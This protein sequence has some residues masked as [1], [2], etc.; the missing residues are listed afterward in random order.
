VCHYP[1]NP[2]EYLDGRRS[3]GKTSDFIL[4]IGNELDHKDAVRTIELLSS[5]FPFRHLVSLGPKLTETPYLRVHRSGSLSDAEVA[6]MYAEAKFVVFPSFYEGFAFPIV[7]ALAYG[8]TIIARRSELLTEV[9]G[10]CST[11]RLIAFNRR[12]ELVDILR[13]LLHGEPVKSEPIGAVASAVSRRWSDVGADIVAFI[14]KVRSEPAR[15]R[16]RERER[17]IDQLMAFRT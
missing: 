2:S 4:V 8:K 12:D 3:D 11:G 14:E 9:A 5:A 16:W 15:S 17:A 13:R 1:F 7:T 10:R 6:R